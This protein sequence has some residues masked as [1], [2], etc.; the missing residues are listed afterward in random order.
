MIPSL[1]QL[2]VDLRDA[3]HGWRAAAEAALERLLAALGAETGVA[4]E[5]ERLSHLAPVALS[6]AVAR[7]GG[8]CLC[9]PTSQDRCL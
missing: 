9:E 2:I 3:D 7:D 8:P 6:G 1:A 4:I 5:T